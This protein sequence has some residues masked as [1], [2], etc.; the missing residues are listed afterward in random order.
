MRTVF[1]VYSI[2]F[3]K[4]YRLIDFALVVLELLMINICGIIGISKIKFF[5]FS[6]TEKIEDEVDL[7]LVFNVL[8]L[9]LLALLV[10]VSIIFCRLFLEFLQ[11]LFQAAMFFEPI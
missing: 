6:G 4:V 9:L 2:S 11:L 10:G 3:L 1:K 7:F 5:N 8:L